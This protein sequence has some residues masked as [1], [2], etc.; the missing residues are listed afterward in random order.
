[1]TSATCCCP[2]IIDR[3]PWATNSPN[4]VGIAADA[5]RS[6]SFSVRRR[7]ATRSATVTIERPWRAQY[8]T[9]SGTRAMLPSSFMISQITPAGWRPASR[10]RSTDASVWPVRSSTPNGRA[11]SGKTWPGWTRSPGSVSG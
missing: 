6:T 11:R 1:M 7:Y 9:R 8:P 4:L 2:S 5:I 10:A 3:Y